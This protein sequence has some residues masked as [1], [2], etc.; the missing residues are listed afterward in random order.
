MPDLCGRL[1]DPWMVRVIQ[2]FRQKE[3]PSSASHRSCQLYSKETGYERLEVD[4]E[5]ISQ[6]QCV[7]HAADGLSLSDWSWQL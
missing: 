6:A 4:G 1:L 5:S 3:T 7:R 2:A